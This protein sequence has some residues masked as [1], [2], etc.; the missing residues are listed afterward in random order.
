M[1]ILHPMSPGD[2]EKRSGL[3]APVRE[4]GFP[5]PEMEWDEEWENFFLW[6]LR[7]WALQSGKQLKESGIPQRLE[8]WNPG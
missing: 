2:R 1:N 4:S 8:S 7:S 6:K 3:I 5:N